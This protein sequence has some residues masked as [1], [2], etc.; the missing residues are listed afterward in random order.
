MIGLKSFN[1]FY[2]EFITLLAKLEFI[3]KCYYKKLYTS[4]LFVYKI[5][6]TLD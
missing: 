1:T 3:K 4:Y 6:K 5:E 2:L